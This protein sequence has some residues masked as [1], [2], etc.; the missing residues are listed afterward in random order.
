LE[1][2]ARWED[3][4]ASARRGGN[5]AEKR[6]AQRAYDQAVADLA[7]QAHPIHLIGLALEAHRNLARYEDRVFDVN[8]AFPAAA[9]APMGDL[10]RLLHG[11]DAEVERALRDRIRAEYG[12]LTPSGTLDPAKNA[13]RFDALAGESVLD[14]IDLPRI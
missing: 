1:K 7:G 2:L 10:A 5:P 6:A 3:D 4:L 14:T 8:A 12:L 11:T 9:R 13:G